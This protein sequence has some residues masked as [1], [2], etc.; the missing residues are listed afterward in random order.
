MG[1]EGGAIEGTGIGLTICKRLIELMKGRIAFSSERGKGSEFW[2]E[3]PE[4][5]TAGPDAAAVAV[6]G[7]E[8]LPSDQ[9]G[10]TV[11]YVDD[12]PASLTLMSRLIADLPNARLLTASTG[13]M[14][15]YIAVAHHPD[16]VIVDIHL[17]DMSGYD[18]LARLK[19]DAE[20]ANIPVMALSADAMPSD[21]AR[22][23]AARFARYMTKP[24]SIPEMIKTIE[25]IV[26]SRAD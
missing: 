15:I 22:G 10:Y 8:E 19:A 1:A 20:T 2:V 24:L 5:R 26:K 6:T 3:L 14:G 9:P 7:S 23:R 16:V 18:V 25:E 21:V 4:D 13:E 12:N 17:P 11:L